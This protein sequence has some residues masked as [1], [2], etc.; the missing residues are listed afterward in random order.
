LPVSI[1]QHLQSRTLVKRFL[2]DKQ[3]LRFYDLRTGRSVVRSY[4]RAGRG[5]AYTPHDPAAME[6][7]WG[8][9]ESRSPEAF[10]AVDDGTIFE[11]PDLVEN[12]KA[13]LALH[14]F[15]VSRFRRAWE[16]GVTSRL[17]DLYARMRSEF[18]PR[19]LSEL[20]AAVGRDVHPEGALE[21]FISYARSKAEF[22]SVF[23]ELQTSWFERAGLH[24][25]SRGL[26][27]F[28]TSEGLAISDRGTVPFGADGLPAELSFLG[29]TALTMP[30]GRH[31]LLSLGSANQRSGLDVQQ[32]RR[33]NRHQLALADRWAYSHP[34]D[35]VTSS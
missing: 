35:D 15:R 10:S 12:L 24:V 34:D 8:S 28:D 31:Q 2:D 6:A 19:F 18:G 1:D 13:L 9:V 4:G 14:Y 23:Q 11:R 27:V 16:E 7:L 29:A 21:A 33:F 3:R 20:S 32:T 5:G 17:G 30:I 22:E 26:E 25:A